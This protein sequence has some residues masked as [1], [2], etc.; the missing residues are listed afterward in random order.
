MAKALLQTQ[1]ASKRQLKEQALMLSGTEKVIKEYAKRQYDSIV[2]IE[3]GLEKDD[4]FSNE[5]ENCIKNL[6][7]EHGSVYRVRQESILAD[8]LESI[9]SELQISPVVSSY[10]ALKKAHD[11]FF[12]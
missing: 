11:K 1:T 7:M 2:F 10:A 8:M 6:I 12:K 4:V 5:H 9:S 3:T